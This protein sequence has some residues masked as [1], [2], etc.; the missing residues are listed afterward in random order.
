MAATQRVRLEAIAGTVPKLIDP[1]PGCRFAARCQYV[2]SRVPARHAAAARGGAGTQ[3]APASL[4]IA[5]MSAPAAAARSRT[6]KKHFPVTRR[7]AAARGRP[8]ARGRRRQLR[9][10]ARG[11]TLGLVG[12]SGC[13]KSHHRALHPAADRADLGRGLFEGRDVAAHAG[14]GAAPPGAR[15]ADHLPGPVRLAQPAHDGRRDRRR[16]AGHPQAGRRRARASRTGSS[17]CWRPWACRPTTCAA[18]R[19][20]SP[21]A[22][23]SASASRARWRSSPS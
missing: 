20:S 22:S 1:P 23:A 19:T 5:R 10:G 15:H 2:S 21:A 9:P 4:D 17:S 16:G 3:G 7:A 11:E 13:G 14:R 18:T 8:G 6:C 12:E